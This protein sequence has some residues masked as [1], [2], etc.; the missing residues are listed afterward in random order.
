M[1]AHNLCYTTLIRSKENL[2]QGGQD[3][4]TLT[5]SGNYFVKSHLRRGIL[6]E[7]LENLLKERKKAKEMMKNEKDPFRYKVLDGRQLALKVSANSVYGFTGAQVGKLPCL[8]I[9]QSVTS[10][11]RTMIEKTKQ[12]VEERYRIDNGYKHDAKVIYGDTDSVMIKFG[13]DNL[14]D[15]MVL[16]REAAEYISKTFI[17]PIKLEF[18]KCYFPY[19]LINKKRYAGLYFTRPDK[20]DKMD[21]KGIETVRRDN[22]PLVANLISIC[23]QKLLVDR[24]PQGAIDYAKQT[25]S[26]LLCNRIDISQLVITKEL[27]KTDKEYAGKQAHVELANKMKKR[28]PGSAPQLGDR[29]PFVIIAGSKGQATYEKAEDPVYVLDHNLPIDTRYYLENQISKPLLRIFEPILHDRAE[30]VLLSKFISIL[31]YSPPPLN[32]GKFLK[33]L[34]RNSLISKSVYWFKYRFLIRKYVIYY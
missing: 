11:G 30:F 29:V 5:P 13:V 17:K 20:F 8:E 23:L 26:D 14:E 28:D 22:S 12:L 34:K 9:S 31:K 27:T 25:I 19:L 33:F 32:I 6:P 16:G 4:Y 10:F 1:I 18:E 21:C 2:P 3:D 7:I 24:D 15:A